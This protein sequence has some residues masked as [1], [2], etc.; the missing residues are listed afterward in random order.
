MPA[1]CCGADLT[2]T[3]SGVDV[4]C[5]AQVVDV[6]YGRTRLWDPPSASVCQVV[7]DA[8]ADHQPPSRGPIGAIVTVDLDYGSVSRRLFTG[9]VQMRRVESAPSATTIYLD[10]VDGFEQLARVNRRAETTDVAVGAGDTIA[11]RLD[12]WL[13]E[14]DWPAGAARD[15]DT[16]DG[17]CPETFIAGN[18]LNQLQR[19]ALADG[20][21]FYI[22][23][24]GTATFR[25]WLWRNTVDDVAAI[26]SD[27]LLY[28]WV[29]YSQATYL[30]DLDEVQNEVVGVRRQWD[31]TDPEPQTAVSSSSVTTYGP[32]GDPLDD[33]ELED[34]GMV[35]TRVSSLVLSSAQPAPRFDGIVVQPGANPSRAWP[36]VIPIDYGALIATN[37][38]YPDGSQAAQ[39]GNVIGQRWRLTQT[40]ASVVLSVSGTGP[41]DAQRIPRVPIGVHVDPVTGL[42]CVPL[43]YPCDT[44]SDVVIKNADGD[45]LAT[46]PPG[47][48]CYCETGGGVVIPDGGAQV[49]YVNEHGEICTDIE[50]PRLRA[51]LWFDVLEP[52]PNLIE[53]VDGDA[54][55][56]GA[57]LSGVRLDVIP[58]AYDAMDT[59]TG[60]LIGASHST[61]LQET[62][63][64]GG[65]TVDFYLWLDAPL[66]DDS[67]LDV[68]DLGPV[69]IRLTNEYT[70]LDVA[71]WLEVVVTD[72]DDIQ[73]LSGPIGMV[74]TV[75]AF[76][77]IVVVW[78]PADIG[79]ELV[80]FL[81][82][83]ETEEP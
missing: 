11:E 36:R 69:K 24:D 2:V 27:R 15:L 42:L 71:P 46:Y 76:Q 21:D 30:D 82:G 6:T 31:A 22:A 50:D 53:R 48:L 49:C 20:G 54:V 28:D 72:E 57:G 75:D 12:R 8:G 55:D 41:W 79:V 59:A 26:F 5:D 34:D 44:V 78:D 81:D 10:A 58:G 32:R 64:T 65:W 51:L 1:G 3:V 56:S 63:L 74:P 47:S 73:H 39:Y 29:P 18:V 4:S 38:L 83:A 7:L 16:G 60:G 37:R 23:G 9:T 43:G 70:P 62:A 66:P 13:D 35:A 40:D 25:S 52:G 33:L 67:H 45:V 14:A 68:I 17:T 80:M 61:P 77:H 19:T